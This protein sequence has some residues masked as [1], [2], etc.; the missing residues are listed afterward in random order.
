MQNDPSTPP[1]KPV[2]AFPLVS[3]K[4]SHKAFHVPDFAYYSRWASNNS[5]SLPSPSKNFPVL[6]KRIQELRFPGHFSMLRI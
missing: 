2:N 4:F 5:A 6:K 3:F 1:L